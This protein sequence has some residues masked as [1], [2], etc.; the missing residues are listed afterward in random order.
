MTL[1]VNH[2][3]TINT[4]DEVLRL[5][6][7]RWKN[8]APIAPGS[9]LSV[10]QLIAENEAIPVDE[11]NLSTVLQT[12]L[13][14]LLP[15]FIDVQHPFCAAHL[16]CRPL[17]TAVLAELIISV[18]NLSMDSWDQSGIGTA[19]EQQ[20]I[21]WLNQLVQYP[22]ES[23]GIFTS[24]GTQSNIM[25]VL[26]AR[27]QYAKQKKVKPFSQTGMNQTLTILC[28]E[29]AH[30]S[31]TQAARFLGIGAENVIKTDSENEIKKLID[32]DKNPFIF[33]ATAG[34]TDFGFIDPLDDI[35]QL[36]RKYDLWMH[37]DAAVGGA[38]LLTQDKSRLQG[39]ENADSLTIDFHKL[40]FQPISA[41]A[42]LVKNKS[43]FEVMHFY[44][45]YLNRRTDEIAGM[46]NLV[47]KSLQTTRRFDALKIWLTWQ[48]L[49]TKKIGKLIEKLIILTKNVA[50]IIQLQSELELGAPVSI[51]TVV[52]RYIKTNNPDDVNHKIRQ[53]LFDQGLAV[54]GE[55]RFQNQAFLK[56]TLMN[57]EVSTSDLESLITLIINQGNAIC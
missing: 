9:A 1:F 35:Y 25:G 6:Q 23:D 30:F 36:C 34:C 46:V 39:L 50:Q 20:V 13:A 40:F 32:S 12:K 27:E 24:G 31:V 21:R 26:L 53:I 5:I 47:S 4:L 43:S 51:N 28:T 44:S 16:H 11:Q 54:I 57:P 37:V 15:Y 17:M 10:E 56:L 22:N 29:R 14:P 49:G 55:T 2:D 8:N 33:V 7:N 52:F 48:H 38:L 3:T 18:C 45:D 19:I 41:S 42:F